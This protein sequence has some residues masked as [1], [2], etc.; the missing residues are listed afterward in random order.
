MTRR[1]LTLGLSLAAVIAI[2]G[3]ASGSDGQSEESSA[4][5][6]APPG[7]CRGVPA[8]TVDS[9][10]EGANQYTITPESSA[11]VSSGVDEFPDLVAIRFTSEGNTTEPV[12]GVWATTIDGPGMIMSANAVADL[13]TD[14][15]A[16]ST[17]ATWGEDH[18]GVMAA[19]GCLDE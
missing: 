12:V 9:I 15:P 13:F 18:P 16:E 11:A 7:E 14:W 10:V 5:G 1:L 17:I 3:C 2:S 19:K 4:A 6:D 8:D